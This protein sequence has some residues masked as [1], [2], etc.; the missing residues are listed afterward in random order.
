LLSFR[1]SLVLDPRWHYKSTLSW[2]GETVTVHTLADTRQ[3]LCV[4]CIGSFSLRGDSRPV[5]INLAIVSEFRRSKALLIIIQLSLQEFASNCCWQVV[6]LRHQPQFA[7]EVSVFCPHL[8][9]IDSPLNFRDVQDEF[10]CTIR[11]E[12]WNQFLAALEMTDH[13]AVLWMLAG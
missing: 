5:E 10:A 4:M 8:N 1:L 11:R 6:I 9:S 12:I 7:C 2:E 3:V 13:T